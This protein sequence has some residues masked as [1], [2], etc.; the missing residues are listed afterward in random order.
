MKIEIDTQGNFEN[1]EKKIKALDS[2]GFKNIMIFHGE[3]GID[4]GSRIKAGCDKMLDKATRNNINIFGGIFPGIFDNG[5]LMDKGSILA[6]IQSDVHF[7]TL[8]NLNEPH[9]IDTLKKGI[10]PI[11]TDLAQNKFHT[12]FVFGDGF[13]E[14]NLNLINSLNWLVKRYPLNVVGGLTGRDGVKA[15]HYTILTPGKI[16]QNGAILAFTTLKSGIGVRHGWKPLPDSGCEVSEINKC[17]IE[18]INKKPALDFYMDF[19]TK[20]DPAIAKKKNILLKDPTL[21]FEEV[22]IKYPLGI[23]RKQGKQQQLIDRTA[24]SVGA[25]KS[26]QFSAEIPVGTKACILHLTGTSSK[27][28]C[29]NIREAAQIAYIE[30]LENF[31]D[32]LLDRRVIIMDCFGRKKMVEKLGQSFENIEFEV[33]T[34]DQQRKNHSP[35]GP[36]TFGEIS[37]MEGGFV[38]LHNKTAVVCTIEDN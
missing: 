12:L 36:L 29:N 27:Q 32:P 15:S 23:I 20:Q 2:E 14:L 30:S 38:E 11:E 3:G 8:E 18:K 37:N 21:F 16:I 31:I 35:M 17:F 13:G 22:A 7:V 19:I 25:D 24:V 34:A 5:K 10:A 28:Q 4:Q 33:I 9:V 26:L 1:I 6:G